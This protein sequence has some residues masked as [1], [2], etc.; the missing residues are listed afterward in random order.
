MTGKVAPCETCQAVINELL[1]EDVW[2]TGLYKDGQNV[3]FDV[4]LLEQL[5]DD[6]TFVSECDIIES[7]EREEDE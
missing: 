1:P 6:L 5:E 3:M 4:A 2:P 7:V